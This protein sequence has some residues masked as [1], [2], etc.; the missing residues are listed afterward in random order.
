[1]ERRQR[2]RLRLV[3]GWQPS[4]PHPAMTAAAAAAATAGAFDGATGT[5]TLRSPRECGL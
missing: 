1:M 3:R 4:V 2:A 5:A